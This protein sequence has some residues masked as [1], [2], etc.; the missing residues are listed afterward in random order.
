MEEK[1]SGNG[2]WC[3]VGY[4]VGGGGV[5]GS[6]VAARK[7]RGR[8]QRSGGLIIVTEVWFRSHPTMTPS[9]SPA[10]VRPIFMLNLRGNN[11]QQQNK[12]RKQQPR[13]AARANLGP[14]SV[15]CA[16]G[17]VLPST[18]NASIL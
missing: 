1:K 11:Q 15:S 8:R 16:P 4:G 17:D 10:T 12:A 9:Y 7:R 3:A 13:P 5:Q 2:R 14:I 6:E 18:A